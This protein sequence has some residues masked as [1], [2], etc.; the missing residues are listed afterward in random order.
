MFRKLLL[1]FGILLLICG[2]SK[3]SIDYDQPVGEKA[4][5]SS[6][7]VQSDCFYTLDYDGFFDLVESEKTTIV[8]IGYSSCPWCRE[9]VPCMD[10]YYTAESIGIYYLDIFSSENEPELKR[11][12][13]IAELCKDFIEKD[14]KGEPLLREPSLVYLQ[15]GK[16]INVHTGTVNTHDATV[17]T[18]TEKEKARL[19]YNLEKEY[20][21][22]MGY[23]K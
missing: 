11:L 10:E 23:G 5:M 2:C 3:E 15:K 7:D 22:L 12:G 19:M 17:R 14:E 20:E 13:E 18:M 6:Y 8:Y 1:L 16:V 21:E 4:D 9:L